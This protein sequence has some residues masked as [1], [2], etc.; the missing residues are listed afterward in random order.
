[1]EEKHKSI[2]IK[3]QHVASKDYSL[4][5]EKIEK[6][7]ELVALDS[8]KVR[9]EEV[10]KKITDTCERLAIISDLRKQCYKEMK[11]IGNC[12]VYCEAMEAWRQEE[13]K[14]LAIS[15]LKS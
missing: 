9:T 3:Y 2:L 11:K 1:M 4:L 15:I 10:K 6:E 13:L 8:I 14:K 12:R 5:L 7:R